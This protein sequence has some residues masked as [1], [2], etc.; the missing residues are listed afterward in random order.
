MT[1]AGGGAAAGARPTTA[2]MRA[3]PGPSPTGASGAAGARAAGSAVGLEPRVAVGSAAV[4]AVVAGALDPRESIAIGRLESLGEFV[5][6]ITLTAAAPPVK[7]HRVA[8]TATAALVRRTIK[9]A[10][11]PHP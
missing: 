1:G 11:G 4:G 6:L 8:A 9:G 2:G 3:W 5:K 10:C 7:A